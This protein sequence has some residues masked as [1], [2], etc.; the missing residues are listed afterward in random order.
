VGNVC[1]AQR[2]CVVDPCATTRCEAGRVCRIGADG[3]AQCFINGGAERPRFDRVI[4]G[5]GYEPRCIVGPT[6]GHARGP[7]PYLVTILALA[8]AVAVVRRRFEG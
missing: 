1:T 5:G 8:A 2:G 4:A 7:N 6:P 3:N